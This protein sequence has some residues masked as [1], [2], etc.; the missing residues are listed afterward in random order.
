MSY[1]LSQPS[2]MRFL[3][4]LVHANN[5]HVFEQLAMSYMQHNVVFMLKYGY[6]FIVPSFS[7]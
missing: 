1:Y 6:R 7:S 3:T 4:R 2:N 5:K